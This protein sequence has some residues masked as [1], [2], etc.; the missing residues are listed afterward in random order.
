[1]S[2]PEPMTVEE[3]IAEQDRKARETG[4]RTR[5]LEDLK[6][7]RAETWKRPSAIELAKLAAVM[8]GETTLPKKFAEV[9]D[10][11][12]LL[13]AASGEA[14]RKAIDK[15]I[16][17]IEAT[18]QQGQAGAPGVAWPR[19]VYGPEPADFPISFDDALKLMTGKGYSR[20]QRRKTYHDF[21][22]HKLLSAGRKEEEIEEATTAEF[23]KRD[24]SGFEAGEFY[25]TAMA[26]DSW[27]KER[28]K[29]KN[30]MKARK[31]WARPRK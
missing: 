11:A 18:G 17:Q 20:G 2:A 16:A 6:G 9:A 1:M 28:R 8:A 5:R 29:K 30:Q 26:M 7:E 3:Q 10:H 4:A 12:L 14:L 23:A 22:H 19:W 31:R 21:C 27:R 24:T 15:E 25:G 13:W